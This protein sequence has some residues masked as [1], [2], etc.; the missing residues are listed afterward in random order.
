MNKN[1]AMRNF[2][3]E[4]AID[5]TWT[6]HYDGKTDLRT[7]NFYTRREAVLNLL[8]NE[9]DFERMLDIG[10][11][12]GDYEDVVKRHNSVYFGIDY[13]AE[14]I[15]KAVERHEGQPANGNFLA[16]SG[17]QLPYNDNMFDLVIAMGYIEYFENPNVT[18]NEIRRVLRPGGTLVMQSYKPELLSWL[19]QRFFDPFLSFIGRGR[20]KP[21]L[22]DSWVNKQYS[23]VQM[24]ALVQ[25]FD[26]TIKDYTY[27]NFY[28]LPGVMRLRYPNLYIKLSEA[29]TRVCPRF[30]GFLATN[31]V[32][33]YQL[34]KDE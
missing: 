1:M 19:D 22:P 33:K 11:G 5:G 28:S 26:F 30:A 16:G 29:I 15:V 24:D 10:C 9:G 20:P 8:K 4:L 12:S 31:Y 3:D 21:K 17:A 25:H 14:M 2:W 23:R 18:M 13:A 7:Y 27:N 34:N 32:G 6:S